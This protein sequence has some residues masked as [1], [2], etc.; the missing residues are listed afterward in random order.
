MTVAF[1]SG[2]SSAYRME[3]K[4]SLRRVAIPPLVVTVMGEF[5]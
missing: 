3:L 5:T 4:P 2:R 1:G